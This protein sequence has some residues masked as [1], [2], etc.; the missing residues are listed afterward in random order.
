MTLYIGLLTAST[1]V[2]D[3]EQFFTPLIV[4]VDLK[5][6]HTTGRSRRFA[7]VQ[8]SEDALGY[9]GR[10]LNGQIVTVKEAE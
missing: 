3:I 10:L 4:S 2:A 7:L 8:V 9:S 5:K 1:T 6:D